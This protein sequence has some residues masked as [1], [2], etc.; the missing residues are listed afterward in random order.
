MDST[1]TTTCGYPQPLGATTNNSQTNFAVFCPHAEEFSLL[2]F[3][4]EGSFSEEI[5]LDP[6]KNRTGDVWHVAIRALDFEVC[7]AYRVLKSSD[8]TLDTINILDPFAK[9]I[10]HKTL[11]TAKTLK[12]KKELFDWQNTF[13]PDIALKNLIIYEMH[14]NAFTQDASSQVHFPGTYKGM[15]EKIP[16]L[17]DLGINAV[18]FLPIQAYRKDDAN[19]VNPITQEKLQNYWGYSP[20]NYF[21]L[22]T[23]YATNPLDASATII[24]FKK[25]VR[26]L[27][28]NKIEVILDIVFN[29]TSE[30][31]QFGPTFCFK[32]LSK[33]TY[34]IISPP[35]TYND[36]TGCGN[37]INTNHP[38]VIDLILQVLRYW[39]IEMK[40]DGFRFDLA[41]EFYRGDSGEFLPTPPI[42]EAI[43]K[44]P[45][46]AKTKLIAEPWDAAG[47][48]QVGCFYPEENRWS[49][50]NANYRD[51]VRRFIKGSGAKESFATRICGSQDL[52]A[53]RSPQTS[54]NFITAHDGFTLKDLVSYNQKHNLANGENNR[55]G[56]S[57]N[58]SWNCG[59]EGDTDD[60]YIKL[61]RKR[62]IRNF[63]LALMISQGVPMVLMGDEY[64]HTKNGNNNSW[65]QNNKLN[66]FLWDEL[67]SEQ[68]FYKFF[69]GL[70]HFRKKHAVFHRKTFLS[71]EDIDWHGTELFN[72]RW[73][74]PPNFI[75][76]TLK[77]YENGQDLYI[78]FNAHRQDLEVEL[79]S[80]IE[81]QIW[82]WVVNTS[83]ESPHDFMEPSSYHQVTENH[84]TMQ[85]YSSIMLIRSS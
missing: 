18:E 10:A 48:Y 42:L 52:Y 13:P 72:P 64:G 16:H 25:L 83:L 71:D 57:F 81:N 75:A 69:K 68:D 47:L 79:P 65:N 58:D 9:G 70:I 19:L 61:L 7:Y 37:S 84:T 46:L 73:N 5:A 26:E 4:E 35:N 80:S 15:I 36:Y 38:I 53:T 22:E 49:E 50:W 34:Y 45:I 29:H 67:K 27:H 41:S 63:H 60:E 39:V 55:D 31:N 82:Q 1:I 74:L 77:D 8:S 6:R 20:I 54:I 44:D 2:L 66:W 24:E 11:Y 32:A 40:V 14:I 43:S 3:D 23:S 51:C 12:A 21:S 85:A 76:L 17:V 78:A 56:N 33:T 28:K 62:Q 59:E 30:G